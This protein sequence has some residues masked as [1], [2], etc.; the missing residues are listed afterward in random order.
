MTQDG[1]VFLGRFVGRFWQQ[2]P[3]RQEAA[4]A[5]GLGLWAVSERGAITDHSPSL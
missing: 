1:A 4:V 3:T 2:T 5:G